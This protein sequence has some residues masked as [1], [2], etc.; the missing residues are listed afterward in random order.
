MAR[1]DELAALLQSTTKDYHAQHSRWKRTTWRHVEDCDANVCRTNVAA[2]KPR[3]A[4]PK[5]GLAGYLELVERGQSKPEA[6][7]G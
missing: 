4:I 7:S 1:C 5:K 2:L 6:S 3:D